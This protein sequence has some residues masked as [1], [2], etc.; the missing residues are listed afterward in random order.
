ML[1][2]NT[3]PYCKIKPLCI[4]LRIH[5]VL[6]YQIVATETSLNSQFWLLSRLQR[7]SQMERQT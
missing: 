7:G 2:H 1:A 6:H 4:S 5:V 3:K